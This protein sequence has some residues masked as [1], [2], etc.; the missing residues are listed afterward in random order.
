[1]DAM[2]SHVGAQT[3]A[4]IAERG[5]TSAHVTFLLAE[6]PSHCPVSEL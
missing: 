2:R 4:A 1:M 3:T 6:I 5:I